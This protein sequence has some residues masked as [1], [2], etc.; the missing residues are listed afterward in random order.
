MLDLSKP[1]VKQAYLLGVEAGKQTLATELD[2]V[3]EV[4]ETR[5]LRELNRFRLELIGRRSTARARVI[6]QAIA[7]IRG[8]EYD[9]SEW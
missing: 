4:T 9:I 2:R 8:E 5:I 6:A 7:L 1:E 3:A